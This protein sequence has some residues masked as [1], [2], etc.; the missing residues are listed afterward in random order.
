M[1]GSGY[2]NGLVGAEIISEARIVAVADVVEAMTSHRPYRPGLG[3]DRALDE[4]NSGSGS[5]FDPLAVEL[6]LAVMEEASSSMK[7]ATK[8]P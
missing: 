8:Y 6:C 5:L 2:P 1:N 4:V 3:L 7:R